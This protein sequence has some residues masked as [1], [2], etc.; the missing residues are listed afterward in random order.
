MPRAVR[1]KKEDILNVA[2]EIV[3]EKGIQFVN[4][5]AI[6]EK[7]NSSVQPIF[8]QFTNMEELKLA[9]KEKVLETYREYISKDLECENPYFQMGKNYIKFAKEEPELFNMLFMTTHSNLTPDIF[10]SNDKSFDQIQKNAKASTKLSDEAVKQFHFKMWIFGHGIATLVA[11][12]TCKFTD[13]QID[14]LLL[15]EYQALMTLEKHKN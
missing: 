14:S 3:R 1:I 8:S 12:N 2:Y 10:A 15:T 7:L 6:A 4:A 11:N 13:E 5:R 9:L